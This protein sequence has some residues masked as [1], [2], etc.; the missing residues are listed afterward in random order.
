[1]GNRLEKLEFGRKGGGQ[2]KDSELC[3]HQ[4][5]YP[6]LSDT[7][8]TY[9]SCRPRDTDARNYSNTLATPFWA[10]D[11]LVGLGGPR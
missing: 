11:A 7:L 9:S 6:P 3:L 8:H 10:E 2:V 5:S 4:C 1:M